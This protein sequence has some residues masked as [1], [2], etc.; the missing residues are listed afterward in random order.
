MVFIWKELR[1]VNT[2]WKVT[3]CWLIVS[4]LKIYEVFRMGSST[5]IVF[6]VNL[7]EICGWLFWVEGG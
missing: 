4:T 7:K 2:Y 5:V 6:V 1:M 3:V